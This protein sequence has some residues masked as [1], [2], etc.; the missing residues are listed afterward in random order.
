MLY[1]LRKC[2]F[3]FITNFSFAQNRRRAGARFYTPVVNSA[4]THKRITCALTVRC[5]ESVHFFESGS[6]TSVTALLRGFTAASASTGR[7]GRAADV[8]QSP[9]THWP[10]FCFSDPLRFDPIRSDPCTGY[11]TTSSPLTHVVNQLATPWSRSLALDTT[12]MA[13][14]SVASLA[15]NTLTFKHDAAHIFLFLTCTLNCWSTYPRNG[16]P[17]ALRPITFHVN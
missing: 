7:L 17:V 10:L 2:D 14:R 9:R 12:E 5:N 6:C 1:P 4:R 3:R 16:A 8:S 11:C 13:A 15:V